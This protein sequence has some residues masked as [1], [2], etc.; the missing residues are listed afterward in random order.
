MYAIWVTVG[1][2]EV[3][4]VERSVEN[5]VLYGRGRIP[6]G[7]GPAIEAYP[8]GY[9]ILQEY[10][11]SSGDMKRYRGFYI[12]DRSRPICYDPGVDHNVDEGILIERFIE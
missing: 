9:K 6:A 2:F 8:S 12:F 7:G 4:P 5:P 1:L 3:E 11:S 10:G